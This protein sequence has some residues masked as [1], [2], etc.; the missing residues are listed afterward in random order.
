MYRIK[1]RVDGSIKRYNTRLVARGF[2]QQEGIDYS[3]TFYPVIKQATLKLVFSIVV[4]C[5]WK[6][7][8]L[9]IHNAFLNGILTEEVYMKQPP[10]LVD[11]AL[12]CH[13]YRLHKLL[14]GLKK[15]PRAWYTHLSDFL[16]SIGF[17]AS[18]V[19][20]SLFILF[21][22]INIFYLLVD[23]DNILFTGSNS[24]MLHRLI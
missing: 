4:S 15:V 10:G 14:Y 7:Y 19:D 12:P 11:S 2:T 1:C 24:A 8:Q 5:N 13:V 22:G 16:L 21:D 23:V 17:H 6:I 18:K 20:T 9:D 3:E